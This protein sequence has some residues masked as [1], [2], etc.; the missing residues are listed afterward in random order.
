MLEVPGALGQ[1]CVTN[2]H[3]ERVHQ[4]QP[5]ITRLLGEKRGWLDAENTYREKIACVGT[6]CPDRCAGHYDI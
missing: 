6:V 5:L 4:L 2:L 3:L 1:E